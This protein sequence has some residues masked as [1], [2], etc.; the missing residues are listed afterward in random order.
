M[1]TRWQQTGLAVLRPEPPAK[2][3]ETRRGSALQGKTR[4]QDKGTSR[5]EEKDK[6]RRPTAEDRRQKDEVERCPSP[7]VIPVRGKGELIE[8]F[9][10]ASAR[11]RWPKAR[12]RHR[13]GK[14]FCARSQAGQTPFNRC[15][16]YVRWMATLDLGVYARADILTR[17]GEAHEKG[18]ASK[19]IQTRD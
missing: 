3:Q 7:A 16:P 4:R 2:S 14:C 11:P 9:N 8:C 1:R 15:Q 18:R 13:A 10:E 17:V 12:V 6:S 5:R 19:Q